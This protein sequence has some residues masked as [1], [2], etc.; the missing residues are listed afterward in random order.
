[1]A[2]DAGGG[3]GTEEG[4]CG[5][6]LGGLEEAANRH[7][8]GPAREHCVGRRARGLGLDLGELGQAIGG[9]VAGQ[10]AVDGDAIPG[11]LVGDTLEVAGEPGAQGVGQHQHG[12][13][14]TH[15]DG[16]DGH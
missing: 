14:L 12:L 2:R 1:M 3:I 13:W 9:G 6:D 4:H 5:G 8:G 16:G 11:N 15:G 7:C 10:H